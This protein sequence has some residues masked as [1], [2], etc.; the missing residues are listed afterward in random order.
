MIIKREEN[1]QITVTS[2]LIVYVQAIV[3]IVHLHFK[4]VLKLD[5]KTQ[6]MKVTPHYK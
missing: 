6:V 5:K 4:L 2:N 1:A 3:L